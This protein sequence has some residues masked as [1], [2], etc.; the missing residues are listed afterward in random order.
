[1]PRPTVA[2]ESYPLQEVKT[3]PA[4]P[5]ETEPTKLSR[6]L[7]QMEKQGKSHI[8][9]AWP[10]RKVN[11]SWALS[12]LHPVSCLHVPVGPRVHRDCRKRE[13]VGPMHSADHMLQGTRPDT[14]WGIEMALM[15]TEHGAHD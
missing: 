2:H 13:D 4:H 3:T 8:F 15:L 5:G 12:P 1:M 10:P 7:E 6:P 11:G 14:N 9:I